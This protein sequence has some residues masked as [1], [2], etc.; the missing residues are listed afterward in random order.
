MNDSALELQEISGP[1]GGADIGI[2]FNIL[3]SAENLNNVLL[4]IAAIMAVAKL[5]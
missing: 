3:L 4:E 1:F 5:S 2:M